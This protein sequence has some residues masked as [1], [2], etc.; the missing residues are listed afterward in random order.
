MKLR[1]WIDDRIYFWSYKAINRWLRRNPGFLYLFELRLRKWRE[2]NPDKFNKAMMESAEHFN[3]ALDRHV[4][5]KETSIDRTT[6][7]TLE[8]IRLHK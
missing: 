8:L 2:A 6:A 5:R 7:E 1:E 4:E 3:D